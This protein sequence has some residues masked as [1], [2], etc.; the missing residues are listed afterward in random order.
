M[1]RDAANKIKS[2]KKKK[3]IRQ[4][5]PLVALCWCCVAHSCQINS[6]RDSAKP[7]MGPQVYERL[8]ARVIDALTY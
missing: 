7:E 1:L 8:W 6:A 5:V 4:F 3:N 2:S